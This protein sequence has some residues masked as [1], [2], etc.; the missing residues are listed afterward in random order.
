MNACVIIPVYN[1]DESVVDIVNRLIALPW[2]NV[3]EIIVVDDGSEVKVEDLKGLQRERINLVRLENNSGYGAAIKAGIRNTHNDCIVII[4]A[5]GTYPVDRIEELVNIY[6]EGNF[7]MVVGARTGDKVCI[8]MLRRPA[9][10]II[11]KLANY[12]IGRK[13]PDLNSGL[14]VMKKD[15]LLKFMHI[16]PSGFSFTST[17]TLAM[18]SNDYLVKFVPID[19]LPRKGKSKIRAIRDTFN[20]IEL[21]CRTVLYFNPLRI[22]IPFSLC[23][24][25]LA[26]IVLYLST[27]FFQKMADV[28]GG[29]I[30]MTSVIV[31]A[32]GMLADLID[33]RMR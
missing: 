3:P 14:R 13:I 23:L 33:K 11:N 8:P 4:D 29:V 27:I 7:D 15:V 25:A 16:L 31:F 24:V 28:T 22:F 32:I 30:L 12:L 17:I 20:F 6:W 21:I 19:Y 9:K 5:D 10:M 26:F 2:E 1:E 18:L